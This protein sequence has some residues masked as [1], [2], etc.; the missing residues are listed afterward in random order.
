MTT[1][2][3]S[4]ASETKVREE[5]AVGHETAEGTPTGTRTQSKVLGRDPDREE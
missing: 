2:I 3:L 4:E 5:R 1:P